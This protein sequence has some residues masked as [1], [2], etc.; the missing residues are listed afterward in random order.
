M[1][2]SKNSLFLACTALMIFT[3]S[4]NPIEVKKE[5]T[6]EGNTEEYE[7]NTKTKQREGWCKRYDKENKIYESCI[8]R[9]GKLEGTRILFLNN[10]DTLQVATFRE[11]SL[12]GPFRD[13]LEG[14]IVLRKGYFE[15]NQM[16][17]IWTYY[18]PSG[19]PKE[20]VTFVKGQEDGP[21]VEYWENGKLKAEGNYK[22]GINRFGIDNRDSPSKEHG[23]LKL[24]D[25]NGNLEKT[26]NCEF[27]LCETITQ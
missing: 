15:N 11:D 17:K 25:E 27:G 14:N 9:N 26:M 23:V 10:G 7:F 12:Q 21:F 24:Y 3:A 18:Y 16:E 4:C 6:P 2:I 22:T 5:K 1:T 20:K 8:Y 19:K 13:F